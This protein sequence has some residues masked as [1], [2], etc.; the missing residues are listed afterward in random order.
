MD[1]GAWLPLPFGFD[2]FASVRGRARRHHGRPPFVER[3]RY[4]LRSEDWNAKFRFG[5]R[6]WL[7]GGGA[8]VEICGDL[9]LIGIWPAPKP[10]KLIQSRLQRRQ[11]GKR[12]AR[13]SEAAGTSFCER[14]AVPRH[15]LAWI[16][17][18]LFIVEV[19]Q[20]CHDG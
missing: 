15:A 5:S 3:R 2:A 11:R 13:L 10:K 8:A 12:A 16:A 14:H 4:A 9:F 18:L 20:I 19:R 7:R 1:N 17:H 6:V